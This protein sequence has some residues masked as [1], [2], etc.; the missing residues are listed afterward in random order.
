MK[1][2]LPRSGRIAVPACDS[3]IREIRVKPAGGRA[4]RLPRAPV[5]TEKA[6]IFSRAVYRRRP[7]ISGDAVEASP[8]RVVGARSRLDERHGSPAAERRC[9]APHVG[10]RGAFRERSREISRTRVFPR[11][12]A[13]SQIRDE[14]LI[15]RPPSPAAGPVRSRPSFPRACADGFR[16]EIARPRRWRVRGAR[17]AGG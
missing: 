10:R 4:R 8:P 15:P 2:T 7:L 5:N 11:A 6:P 17:V 3:V 14:R 16:A 9:R 13:H 1:C 12:C